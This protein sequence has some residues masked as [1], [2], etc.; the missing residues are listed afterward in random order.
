VNPTTLYVGA[1]YASS[2]SIARRRGISLP[3]EIAAIFFLLTIGFLFKPMFLPVVSFPADVVQLITPWGS[4]NA[5]SRDRVSRF[6]L[7]D[8]TMQF[9]PWA[10]QA[11]EAWRSGHLPLWNALSGCG[12]PLLGNAQS[13]AFSPLLLA[14]LPLPL[15]YAETAQAAMKMLAAM[16]FMYLFCRR[17]SGQMPSA[18][19]AVAFGLGT[20]VQVWLHFP[21]TAVAVLLPAVMLHIDMVM[22]RVTFARVLFGAVTW[23]CILAAGHPETAALVAI[24]AALFTLWKWNANAL[25]AAVS[26]LFGVLFAATI[27][28]TFVEALVRS[29]RLAHV[30][31]SQLGVPFSDFPSLV[32]LLQPQAYG[33]PMTSEM[34]CGFVGVAGIAAG[35]IVAA[36]TIAARRWRSNEAFLVFLALMS[37]WIM[38]D[39][40]PF[41]FQYR[42]LAMSILSPRMRLL[43]S[44]ALAA[45]IA[46]ALDGPARSR[47]TL[48]G[49]TLTAVIMAYAATRF[50]TVMLPLMIP[51]AV[52]LAAMFISRRELVIAATAFELWFNIGSFN[53]VVPVKAMYPRT[54]LI[55]TLERLRD[56]AREPFR[57]TGVGG[58]FF[59]NSQAMFGFEDIRVH[60]PMA[61]ERYVQLLR[62]TNGYTSEE[63]YAKFNDPDTTLIDVLN[64]TYMITD[65]GYAMRDQERYGLIYDGSDGRIWENRHVRQRFFSDDAKVKI[66]ESRGDTYELEIDARRETI[67]ESS[68]AR[69]PGWRIDP[70]LKRLT[71][72]DALLAFVVPKGHSN[73]RV[74]YVPRTFWLG[75]AIS[76][77]GVVALIPIRRRIDTIRELL[78]PAEDS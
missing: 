3:W 20:F 4:Y 42:S 27:V 16:T 2:V 71:V 55:T 54:P 50:D 51:S 41:H 15:G 6:Q 24:C 75:T 68:I 21:H 9:V 5:T 57:V 18:A 28:G 45:M 11:R 17:R 35:V 49:V 47:A 44:F 12:Y 78:Q 56:E 14:T 26:L 36:R 34:V 39:L 76:L 62:T 25:A 48:A 8:T 69:Y 43:F 23:L 65:P 22:E 58:A 7:Q 30:N 70:P 59:P 19:A 38:A 10:H 33:R 67:V 73:V 29:Q 77:L 1:I 74:R 63:Y 64:V 52:V 60:D 66:V 32:S 13:A 53:A 31:A 46:P 37:L 40:P 72:H 61:N